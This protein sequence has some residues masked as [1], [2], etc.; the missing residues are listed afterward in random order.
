MAR[1]EREA[2]TL[3]ALNHPNIA[4]I[5]GLEESGAVSALVME[6]V[7][8]ETLRPRLR[9]GPLLPRFA[10]A[11]CMQISEIL[12]HMHRK[13]IAHLDLK[14]ENVLLVDGSR[15]RLMDFGISQATILT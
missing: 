11:L 5:Y 8:G 13:G 6:L 2:K 10:L 14:P 9:L 1:F 4:Q 12:A 3:A 7:E 15:V